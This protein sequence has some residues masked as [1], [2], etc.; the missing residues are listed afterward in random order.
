MKASLNNLKYGQDAMHTILDKV[1]PLQDVVKNNATNIMNNYNI[2][3]ISKKNSEFNITLID[4]HTNSI[5]N[6]NS[7]LIDFENN[8]S[9]LKKRYF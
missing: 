8:L 5:K 9:D 3:Q 4:N 7:S 2:S 1:T 6:I